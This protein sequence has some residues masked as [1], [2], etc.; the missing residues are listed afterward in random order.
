MDAVAVPILA[1]WKTTSKRNPRTFAADAFDRHYDVRLA[2]Y[3][4]G[5]E[6]KY[7]FRPEIYIVAIQTTGGMAVNVYQ[8]PAEWLEDAEARLLLACDEMDNFDIDKHLDVG[9]VPL[10]Q[11]RYAVLDLEKVA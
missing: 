10:V 2:M 1:D 3:A 5:F 4:R 6:D 11:P 8:M 7:G 9:P